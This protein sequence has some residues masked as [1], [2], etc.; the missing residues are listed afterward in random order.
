M[1]GDWKEKGRDARYKNHPLAA[2]QAAVMHN[3]ITRKLVSVS[4]LLRGSA[5]VSLCCREA[6]EK[7]KESARGP[8]HPIVHPAL[9]IFRLLL[10]LLGYPAG[11][12]AKERGWALLKKNEILKQA[13]TFLLSVFLSFPFPPP[14]TQ[15]IQIVA[16]LTG[17]VKPFTLS[18]SSLHI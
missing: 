14:S 5:E 11:A 3:P 4:F 2:S 8:P 17:D 12:F 18:P 10:I 13:L 9:S 7:E 6:G 1:E 15:A 16:S